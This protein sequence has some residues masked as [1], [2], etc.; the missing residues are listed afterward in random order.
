MKRFNQFFLV[1]IAVVL[2]MSLAPAQ[3]VGAAD[4]GFFQG[5]DIQFYNP[6]AEV[7]TTATSSPPIGN[8]NSE[9]VYKYLVDKGL[10]GE[11]AAGFLGNMQ[12]ES[13]FDPAVRQGGAIAPS[14]FV[15]VNEE[16]FGLVQWTFGGSTPG[17]RQGD[18]YRLSQSTNRSITDISLQ[19]DYVWEELSGSFKTTLD[20]LEGITDPVEAAIIVHDNYEISADTPAEVRSVRGGAAQDFFN[21]YKEITPSAISGT[22]NCQTGIG[23]GDYI[24]DFTFYDQCDSEWGN[25]PSPTGTLVCQLAC[26]PTSVAMIV[27]NMIGKD[28][29]PTDT[30]DYVFDNNL[31]LPN[32]SGTDLN[33]ASKLA[34]KY[35]LTSEV[36][37][38]N[39]FKDINMYKRVLDEGGMIMVA[40][41][42]SVPFIEAPLAHFIVIRGIT[43]SGNFIVAD[44]SPRTEDTNTKE[45]DADE[46][47]GK[48]FGA[49]AFTK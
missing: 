28:V 17:T 39:E 1:L 48:T 44:P 32:D 6:D 30:I 34:D 47:I 27:K 26:G 35:G 4:E 5:N 16:G 38:N 20:R 24:N 9:I 14:D 49:V 19:M 21:R 3:L 13:G 18:L 2:T 25:R 42:G 29:T 15:P 22:N 33:T 45:W 10:T 11:Q 46:I 43:P 36:F 23:S 7:C 40:G 8:E 12:Q 31:W 41:Q 37:Y